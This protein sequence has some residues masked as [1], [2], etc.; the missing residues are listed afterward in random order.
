MK[1]G[2]RQ[3]ELVAAVVADAAVAMAAAVE[4]VAAVEVATV[5]AV[6]VAAIAVT[7]AIAAI[8]GKQSVLSRQQGGF[9]PEAAKPSLKKF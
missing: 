8:V 6:D 9:L 1:H 2:R 4:A 3:N 7:E 5:E